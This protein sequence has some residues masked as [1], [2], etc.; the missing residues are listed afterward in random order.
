MDIRTKAWL[1]ETV[2]LDGGISVVDIDNPEAITRDL[3][4]DLLVPLTDDELEDMG[5]QLTL[6]EFQAIQQR[7]RDDL[8]AEEE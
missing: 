3:M 7:L 1:D 5:P 2:D 4:D 6:G 8:R